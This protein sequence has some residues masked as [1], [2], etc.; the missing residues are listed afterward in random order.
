MGAHSLTKLV[1]WSEVT[2]F[3]WRKCRGVSLLLEEGGKRG[4]EGHPRDRGW[5]IARHLP[6]GYSV[7]HAPSHNWPGVLFR[8]PVSS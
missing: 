1:A 3:S 4:K 2:V 5:Q 7:H 8:G 6:V